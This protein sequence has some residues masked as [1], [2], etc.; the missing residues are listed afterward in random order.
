M[1]I[2]QAGNSHLA[3]QENKCAMNGLFDLNCHDSA[4]TINQRDIVCV[5]AEGS[6][7]RMYL[8]DGQNC[9][10]SK[11]IG[12]VEHMLE[13]GLFNR[14]HRSWII[15]MLYIRSIKAKMSRV[16]LIN[17][18]QVCVSRRKAPEFK[19]FLQCIEK[20]LHKKTMQPLMKK[21]DRL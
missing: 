5:K 16:E 13:D 15:N 18:I 8:S 2:N 1:E 21:H 17:G 19:S 10:Y 11:R 9:L 20:Q 12:I 3:N 7:S 6:Y 4:M 14:C